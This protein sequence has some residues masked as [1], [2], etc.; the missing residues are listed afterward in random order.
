M[1]PLNLI[2]FAYGIK[3]DYITGGPSWVHSK[4]Y[5]IHAKIAPADIKRLSRLNDDQ[6][7]KMLMQI[8]TDRFQLKTHHEEKTVPIYQLVVAKGGPKIKR[9]TDAYESMATSPYE[10]KVVGIHITNLVD[11]L[12][13][14]LGRKVVDSTGMDGI[15]TFDLKFTPQDQLLAGAEHD[16]PDIYTALQQQLGLELR[17]AKGTVDYVV[18]DSISLPS[19][20]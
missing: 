6:K 18:V 20:N 16:A 13:S 7:N 4:A 11:V 15:Y 8:L 9:A 14:M 17:P 1:S 2:S 5:D 19:P 12:W 10:I 3:S